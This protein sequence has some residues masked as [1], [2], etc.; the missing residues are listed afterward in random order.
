MSRPTQL[1]GRRGRSFL[2][3]LTPPPLTPPAAARRAQ[4]EPEARAG[5]QSVASVRVGRVGSSLR[6]AFPPVNARGPGRIAAL[7]LAAPRRRHRRTG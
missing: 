6:A 3:F 4:R 5:R 1:A 2:P 7:G